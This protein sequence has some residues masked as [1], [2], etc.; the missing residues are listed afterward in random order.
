MAAISV[1]RVYYGHVFGLGYTLEIK[2]LIEAGGFFSAKNL[3]H[4]NIR[5][6]LDT[7]SKDMIN[8]PEIHPIGSSHFLLSTTS[9]STRR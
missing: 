8:K 7:F 5:G 1:K 9:E 3:G 4:Q 6:S 2:E